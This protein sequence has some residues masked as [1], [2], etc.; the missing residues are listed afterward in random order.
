MRRY[1]N[2]HGCAISAADGFGG[3]EVEVFN[4]I[5][6]DLRTEIGIL[7]TTNRQDSEMPN[8]LPLRRSNI[9]IG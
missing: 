7:L 1:A 4:S 5:R 6:L 8:P 2:E 9:R 3:A